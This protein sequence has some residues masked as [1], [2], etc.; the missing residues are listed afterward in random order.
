MD[1][2]WLLYIPDKLVR[3]SISITEVIEIVKEVYRAH[4]NHEAWLSE[5]SAQFLREGESQTS[6]Y[7]VKGASIPSRGVAG[8]RIVGNILSKT[9]EQ[10]WTYRYCYL[11]DP[12]TARPLAIVDEY[13]QSLLRTGVTGAVALSLLGKRESKIL[14]IVG[15]GHIAR[16][17]LEAL[18]RFFS[19]EEVR[20]WSR[21]K[22]TQESFVREMGSLLDI[23]IE[24]VE[25]PEMVVRGADLVVTI[26]DAD[27]VLVSPGWLSAGATLCSMGNNQEL[28][29]QILDEVDKF[30]VDDFDFCRTVGDIHAWM[31][32]GYLKEAEIL[33]R[34]HGTIPEVITGRKPGRESKNEKILAVIQGMASCDLAIARLLYEKLRD[35]EQVQRIAI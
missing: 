21:S 13:Y 22:V 16:H 2:N 14:G 18:P 6:N 9:E 17:L 34:L 30:I 20:V 35:S 32:R 3:E 4:G 28:N 23:E 27:E 19:L 7:K 11:A 33:E 25:T 15:A 5:P 8:F 1:K 10:S 24:P 26:T 31:S 12:F 29:P